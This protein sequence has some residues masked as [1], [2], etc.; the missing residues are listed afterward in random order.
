[1]LSKLSVTSFML[2]Q[3]SADAT[4]ERRSYHGYYGPAVQDDCSNFN[5]HVGCTDGQQTRYPDDWSQR[6]FQTFLKDGVDAHMYKPE[7]EGLG[8]IM[9]YNKVT[10]MADK[11]TAKCEAICRKHDSIVDV[12]YNWNNTGFSSDSTVSTD[13]KLKDA[14]TLVVK[15]KD[16]DGKEFQITVEPTN[17]I[18]QAPPVNQ[19]DNYKKGQKG[20]I[21]ELF[22]WPYADV[23]EECSFL[24]KA[25]YMGVKVFPPQE[26]I[27][28]NEWP[29]N[30]ELNP[31]Y[32]MY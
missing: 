18:W 13:T 6:A 5:G 23:K 26:S 9:C 28:S 2:A 1:M 12:Q 27:F 4:S 21:V 17:F 16:G 25:G 14:M 32:F 20:A 11:T 10:Y 7:Y 22:G 19:P 3:A 29:Q 31:W 24:A 8:R 30:G 15:A